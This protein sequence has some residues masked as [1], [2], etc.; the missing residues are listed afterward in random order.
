M[1]V[2]SQ[3]KGEKLHIGRDITITILNI[4]SGRVKLG[5]D[6]PADCQILRDALYEQQD[7]DKELDDDQYDEWVI[8]SQIKAK[9]N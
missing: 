9:P 2:I 3:K 7:Q 8:T 4:Q 5:I 1:L 6:A